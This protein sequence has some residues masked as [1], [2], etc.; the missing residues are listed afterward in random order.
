MSLGVAD[1]FDTADIVLQAWGEVFC[2]RMKLYSAPLQKKPSKLQ[3]LGLS[4]ATSTE[5]GNLA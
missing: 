5:L 4:G 3:A 2:G 1:W